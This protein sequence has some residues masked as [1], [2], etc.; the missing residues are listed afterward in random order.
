MFPYLFSLRNDS[1]VLNVLELNSYFKSKNDQVGQTT[2]IT[3]YSK[4]ITGDFATALNQSLQILSSFEDRQDNYGI[5]QAYMQIAL[6]LFYSG[7]MEQSITY[8][9]SDTYGTACR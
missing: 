6:A 5:M 8:S 1:S 7:D 9:K 2:L 3:C 4:L